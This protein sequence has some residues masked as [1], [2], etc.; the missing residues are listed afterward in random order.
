[1]SEGFDNLQFTS[2]KRKASLGRHPHWNPAMLPRLVVTKAV[3]EKKRITGKSGWAHL[4][5][6]E[7]SRKCPGTGVHTGQGS[8]GGLTFDAWHREN[9]AKWGQW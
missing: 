6:L 3:G 8:H 9:A 7:A 4:H 2:Q 5:P 1:M